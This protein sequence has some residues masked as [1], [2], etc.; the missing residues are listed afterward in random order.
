MAKH[1]D[2]EPLVDDLKTLIDAFENENPDI[3]SEI[4]V[5]GIQIDE[6]LRALAVS[7]PIVTTTNSTARGL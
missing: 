1:H 4:D 3:V 5:L 6:Y 7:D 2:K